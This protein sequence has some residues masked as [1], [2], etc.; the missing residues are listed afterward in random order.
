MCRKERNSSS[1]FSLLLNVLRDKLIPS[2]VKI[3]MSVRMRRVLHIWS[4]IFFCVLVFILIFEDL[5]IILFPTLGWRW[6]T[7]LHCGRMSYQED[8]AVLLL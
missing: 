5:K 1:L 7:P 3:M 8:R 6:N 2:F 4:Y